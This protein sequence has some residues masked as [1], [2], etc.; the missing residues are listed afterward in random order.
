M[1]I[2]KARQHPLKALKI[3]DDKNG[4]RLVSYISESGRDVTPMLDK[5]MKL[6]I[7][8]QILLFLK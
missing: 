8:D 4:K 5:I 1:V 2:S 3:I 6:H 7:L